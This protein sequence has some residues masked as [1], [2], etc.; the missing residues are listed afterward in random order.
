MHGSH[1]Y[2]TLLQPIGSE[3]HL[4][5][6]H[7]DVNV[8][9]LPI[10]TFAQYQR[11]LFYVI[12]SRTNG[13]YKRC[14]FDT[15]IGK[16][17]IFAGIPQTLPLPTCFPGDVMHQPLINLAAL[18]LNLW[19]AQPAT[20]SHNTSTGWPWMVLTRDVW[21]SHG[22]VVLRAAQYLQTSFGHTP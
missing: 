13:K 18:L 4:T 8:N 7:P 22:K 6:G 5:S 1:Y 3:D 16:P 9:T 20:C 15:G 2:P 11:D 17:S 19:C 12:S 10:L 14:C 21:K